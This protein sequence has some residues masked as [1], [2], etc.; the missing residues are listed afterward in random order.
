VAKLPRGRYII[1]EAE[2]EFIRGGIIDSLR[3][4]DEIKDGIY[5]NG[6]IVEHVLSGKLFRIDIVPR[7]IAFKALTK[8][9]KDRAERYRAQAWPNPQQRPRPRL[10][11]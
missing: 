9:Q 2:D 5:P 3:L 1:V 11:K 10:R 6:T 4:K 7:L 8:V